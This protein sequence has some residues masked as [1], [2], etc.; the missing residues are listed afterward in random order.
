L[1]DGAQLYVRGAPLSPSDRSIL[2]AFV[3]QLA[4]ALLQRRLSAQVD[5]ARP[6]AE[7]DRMRSALLA[8]VGHDVRRPLASA[9]AA[10]SALRSPTL[11]LD[12]ADRDALLQTADESLGA[13]SELLTNLLDVSRLQAGALGVELTRVSVDELA[14]DALDELGVGPADVS[15]DLDAGAVVIADAVLARRALVNLIANAQRFAPPGT[16]PMVTASRWLNRVQIRVIDSGPGVAADR[17]TEIFLPFQRTTDTDNTTGLGLGLALSKGFI[18]AMGGTLEAED[19]PG[20]GLTMVIDLPGAP[21]AE[22][23]N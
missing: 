1:G 20:G 14:G 7:A 19:T 9:T 15:L 13:L 5:A 18:E 23:E 17:R 11:D 2:G 22:E 12:P 8:S 4:A 3:A 10:V 21:V 6:V 16:P